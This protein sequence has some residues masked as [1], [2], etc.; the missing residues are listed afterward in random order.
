MLP[1]TVWFDAW[2]P[3]ITLAQRIYQ[4]AS[5]AGELAGQ[6]QVIHSAFMPTVF[7]GLST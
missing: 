3:A 5:R 1:E 4:N 2:M 6:A 7:K